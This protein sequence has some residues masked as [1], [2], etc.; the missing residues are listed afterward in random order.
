MESEPHRVGSE[1]GDFPPTVTC[2]WIRSGTHAAW[3]GIHVGIPCVD[4]ESVA[5][6]DAHVAAAV[7]NQQLRAKFGSG[8]GDFG[9][10]LDRIA[11]VVIAISR[12]RRGLALF[13]VLPVL[14]RMA[15]EIGR[16]RDPCDGLDAHMPE[17]PGCI[18]AGHNALNA[19]KWIS[20]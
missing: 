5:G 9:Y 18:G 12:D 7:V 4:R 13:C 14:S 3:S 17:S 16:Q 10:C 6:N 2:Y 8:G 11:F 19:Q 20:N 15:T 1:F